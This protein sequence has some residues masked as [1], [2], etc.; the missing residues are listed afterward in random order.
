MNISND[1]KVLQCAKKYRR[2]DNDIRLKREKAESLHNEANL[3]G[4]E[5]RKLDIE[6]IKV[7]DLLMKVLKEV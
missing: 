3:L 4:E 2:L 1:E 5:A 6:K 7:H